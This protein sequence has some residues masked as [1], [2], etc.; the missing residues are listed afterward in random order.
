MVQEYVEKCYWPSAQRFAALTADHL[1]KARDLAIWRRRLQ[2]SWQQ[3]RIENVD[4]AGADPMHVGAEL[5]VNARVNLGSFRPD[6]VNVQLFHGV[7]DSLGEIPQPRTASM[8][9]TTSETGLTSWSEPS[10]LPRPRGV[11]TA[12]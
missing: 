12:S 9:P 10:F 11:R 2:D 4:T 6:D 8:S 1:K 7:V 5:A 3:I